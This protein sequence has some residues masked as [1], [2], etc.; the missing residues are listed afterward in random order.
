MADN[1]IEIT[2]GDITK[3]TVAAI[4]KAAD[5][6]LETVAFPAI[7]TGFTDIRSNRPPKWPWRQSGRFST[8]IRRCE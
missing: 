1:R 6:G 8:I 7:S 2:T 4:V 5:N 3:L